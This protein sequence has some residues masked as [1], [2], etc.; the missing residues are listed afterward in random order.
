MSAP[1]REPPTAAASSHVLEHRSPRTSPAVQ[2]GPLAS[3]AMVLVQTCCGN[4]R[5]CWLFLMSELCQALPCTEVLFYFPL[6]FAVSG[7]EY[8]FSLAVWEMVVLG[9]PAD[10]SA[11]F[12][13]GPLI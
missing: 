6:N 3:S 4:G 13:G 12:C 2:R 11:A 7:F 9:E 1:D 8:S 5:Q 10:S